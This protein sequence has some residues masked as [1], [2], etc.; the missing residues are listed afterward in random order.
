MEFACQKFER[1]KAQ[2]GGNSY[3]EVDHVRYIRYSEPDYGNIA[4]G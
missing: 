3:P 2:L 4:S 1:A